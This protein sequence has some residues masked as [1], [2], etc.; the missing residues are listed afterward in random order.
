MKIFTT[1]LFVSFLFFI[2]H[3]ESKTMTEQ[4]TAFD[5]SFKTLNEEAPMPLSAYKGKVL[6][7]VNTASKCGFTKQYEGLET[8]YKTYKDQGLVVIGVPSDNFGGQEFDNNAEIAK[9]CAHNFGVTFPMTAKEN[10]SGEA[11]HEFYQWSKQELG[12]GTAPKWNFHKYLI[13]R[14]GKIIDYFGS[15]TDPMSG[16]I[17]KAIEQALKN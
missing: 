8:L 2:Q 1:F 10:V 13:G 5:F 17:T 9:F 6:L 15:M 12:F 3:A 11:A 14:E 16:K 4:K 7:I